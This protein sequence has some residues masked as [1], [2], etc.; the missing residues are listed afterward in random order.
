MLSTYDN[1]VFDLG[2]VIVDIDCR[3][4]I[5]EL[6]KLGLKDADKLLDPYKQKG[7]FLDL[8][9]GKITAAEFLDIMR[10]MCADKN[11]SNKALEDAFCAF[12]TGLPVERLKALRELRKNKKVYA[13]SNT[14]A[15]LFN[16]VIERLFRQEGYAINDY[17]DGIIA[18]FADHA[19]KP[20]PAIFTTL[21]HRYDLAGSRTLFLDDS[22]ANCDAA[23]LCGIDSVLVPEGVEFMEIL[24]RIE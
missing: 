18:S 22:Q 5:N 2:G 16:S 4:C 24:S 21:L 10:G 20:D 6:Q 8:E 7:A 11:I 15:I 17:F 3:A 19:C 23:K 14:N 1:I 9:E 12:I 13:L